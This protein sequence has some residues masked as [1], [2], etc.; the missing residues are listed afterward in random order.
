VSVQERADEA[1]KELLSQIVR[2]APKEDG[3]IVVILRGQVTG[4][5]EQDADLFWS[6]EWFCRPEVPGEH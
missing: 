6:F 5:T 3:E 1:A 2:M 4:S